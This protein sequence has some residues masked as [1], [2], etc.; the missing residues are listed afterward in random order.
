[1]ENVAL[2][3]AR[4]VLRQDPGAAPESGG[5]ADGNPAPET[6]VGDNEYDGRMGLRISA[7]FV[8]LIGS[9]FGTLPPSNT[10]STH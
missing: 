2:Q 4:L 5:D 1:M 6:C 9:T 3:V 8:I 10:L 7:I